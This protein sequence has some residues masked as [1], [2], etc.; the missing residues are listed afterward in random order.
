MRF[1]QQPLL[2]YA[3]AVLFAAALAGPAAA[4]LPPAVAVGAGSAVPSRSLSPADIRIDNFGSINASYY[5]GAQPKGSDYADLAAL[6]VRTVIDL[7]A[8]GDNR[9]EAELVQKAGMIFYRIPMTT[10]KAP[11]AE[12]I[13][14]FSRS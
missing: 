10:H 5:R 2:R 7:Q 11:T 13:A 8:D 1:H 9:D 14:T 3:L 4:Q 12:Q 6:G